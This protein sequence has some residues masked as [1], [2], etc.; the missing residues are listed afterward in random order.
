MTQILLAGDKACQFMNKDSA[1]LDMVIDN[2]IERNKRILNPIYSL[3]SPV[4]F[5]IVRLGDFE[6]DSKD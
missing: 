6:Y 3:R 5:F 2:Y 1:Y 4:G